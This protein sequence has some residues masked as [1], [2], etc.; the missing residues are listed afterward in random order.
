M[1]DV[2][3]LVSIVTPSYNQ[4]AFLR[5]TIESVLAQE[6]PRVEY[7][8]MDG[9]ST[10]GSVEII[11]EYADRLAYWQSAPDAGQAD[12]INEGWKRAQGEYLAYLNSDDT[13]NPEA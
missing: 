6:Y 8:V 10:D 9:G 11:R 1:H 4:A 5:Q 3:P 12:A 13:L 7:I 2:L